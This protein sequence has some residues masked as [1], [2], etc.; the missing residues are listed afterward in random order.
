[1]DISVS[2]SGL[3]GTTTA[4]DVHCCTLVAGNG[5][6]TV[7]LQT[8]SLT[9]FPLGESSGTSHH[10]FNSTFNG[11]FNSTFLID[12]GGTSATALAALLAGLDEG[13]AYFNIATNVFP[14]GEI[15]GFF[16]ATPIPPAIFLFSTG[17]GIIGWLGSRRRPA[18][19]V[20]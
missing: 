13:Q 8:L 12:N 9:G 15:R 7:A 6:T 1:M 18:L 3:V 11:T 10:T 19:R 14:G 2:F 5:T 16:V 17:L 4:A 20:A